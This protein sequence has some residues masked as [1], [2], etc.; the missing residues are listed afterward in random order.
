L[1]LDLILHMCKSPLYHTSLYHTWLLT[2]SR[3]SLIRC[4]TASSNFPTKKHTQI[5]KQIRPGANLLMQRGN[6]ITLWET[7][8][9]LLGML[10]GSPR[11]PPR[12]N[13]LPSAKGNNPIFLAIQFH[14]DMKNIRLGQRTILHYIKGSYF[15]TKLS[16]EASTSEQGGNAILGSWLG[17]GEVPCAGRRR[18]RDPRRPG[19]LPPCCWSSSHW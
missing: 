8:A 7:C 1:S 14:F 18:G 6:K 11:S 13:D 19:R 9:L 15:A 16:W 2:F 10:C 12:P 17:K 4:S 5:R 3:I